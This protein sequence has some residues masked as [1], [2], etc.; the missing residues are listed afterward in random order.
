[1]KKAWKQ[2][3]LH[4]T[5]EKLVDTCL[6]I[7]TKAEICNGQKNMGEFRDK[8]R[9]SVIQAAKLEQRIVEPRAGVS[10]TTMLKHEHDVLQ[11]LKFDTD[12][13]C[14]V[15]WAFLSYHGSQ[16][17]YFLDFFWGGRIV[18]GKARQLCQIISLEF[19]FW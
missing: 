14:T 1:M 2:M 18:S 7:Y 13:P 3:T 5:A 8:K 16:N 19:V 10:D 17:V 12:V 15:Q 11:K 4:Q 6:W 9:N